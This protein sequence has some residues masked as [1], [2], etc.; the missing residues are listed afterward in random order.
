NVEGQVLH[1]DLVGLNG[2]NFVMRDRQTRSEWQQA[3]GEA[4]AG[5]LKGKRLEVIPFV[6]TTWEEGRTKYPGTVALKPD[7]IYGDRY[8]ARQ[9]GRGAS[10]FGGQFPGQVINGEWSGAASPSKWGL[11]EDSRL[12]AREQIMGI[13]I[14]DAHKAY[15]LAI[16]R[17][18]T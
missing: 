16:L 2:S 9:S 3:T 12:P 7:P 17:D 14:G 15:P 13:E 11:K 5:P 18:L 4:I 6:I 1:F 10:P 8:A